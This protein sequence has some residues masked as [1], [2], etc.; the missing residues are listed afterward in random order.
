LLDGKL[1]I[2][3]A[4]RVWLR[5]FY[6]LELPFRANHNEKSPRRFYLPLSVQPT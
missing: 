3:P 2:L 1:K 4:L 6:D 5:D